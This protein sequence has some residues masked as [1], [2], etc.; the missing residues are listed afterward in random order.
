METIVRIQRV[1][2]A[3]L[4]ADPTEVWES[5]CRSGIKLVVERSQAVPGGTRDTLGNG[6]DQVLDPIN[7]Q[8]HPPPAQMLPQI[9]FTSKQGTCFSD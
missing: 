8:G 6:N 4:T 1:E 2:I 9:R 5:V 3:R 7:S